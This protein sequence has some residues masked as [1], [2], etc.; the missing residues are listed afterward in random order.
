MSLNVL[1]PAAP[2][3]LVV[4]RYVVH[5]EIRLQALKGAVG[6]VHGAPATMAAQGHRVGDGGVHAGRA[7][8]ELKRPVV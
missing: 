1:Y 6:R 3:R 8:R 2:S 5:A 7:V 4:E